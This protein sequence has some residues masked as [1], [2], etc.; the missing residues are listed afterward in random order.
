[1][2]CLHDLVS[3]ELFLYMISIS[4]LLRASTLSKSLCIFVTEYRSRENE[5]LEKFYKELYSMI[6]SIKYSTIKSKYTEVLG[7]DAAVYPLY[8]VLLDFWRFKGLIFGF[9]FG[10]CFTE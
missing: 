7:A 10:F 9:L 6:S 8:Y 3:W 5:L 2:V 1:M 4:F